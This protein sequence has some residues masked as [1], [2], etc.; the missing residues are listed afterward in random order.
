MSRCCLSLFAVCLLSTTVFADLAGSVEAPVPFNRHLIRQIGT[1]WWHTD[2]AAAYKEARRNN[3]SLFIFFRD[4]NESAAADAYES[5]VLAA[6][7]LI[8]DF[9]RYVRAVLS[10]SDRLP[11]AYSGHEALPARLLEHAAFSHLDGRQGIVIV[12][13]TEPAS[14]TYGHVVS[15]H[16]FRPGRYYSVQATKTVLR[17]PP[18]TITQ[19]ALVFAVRIHPESPASTDGQPSPILFEQA[20]RHS[21]LM[22]RLRQVGHHDWNR[23]F[24]TI[25]EAVGGG[26]VASEVAAVGSGRTLIEAAINCVDAWRQSPGHWSSVSSRQLLYGYDL[27][28][29]ADGQWYA[30]G[31]F[32][33]PDR[34]RITKATRQVIQQGVEQ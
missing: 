10:T 15:A 11:S 14:E 22:A 2:Y 21:Q 24:Y 4:E 19:R 13:L 25:A 1:L 31:I 18:G 16:P 17:L 26:L 32:A 12:D 7:E 29:G 20:R 8:G 23:R 3:K 9:S 34:G 28:Q 5:R 33:N 27:K 6:E 30:T